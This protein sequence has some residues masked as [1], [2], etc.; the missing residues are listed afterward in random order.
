MVNTDE[1]RSYI[2]TI[3]PRTLCHVMDTQL[4]VFQSEP[5]DRE[6]PLLASSQ[7]A[8]CYQDKEEATLQ[9]NALFPER[10]EQDRIAFFR[11]MSKE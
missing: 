2:A 1:L 5:P 4:F 3:P 10:T 9:W 8:G 6:A 11:T 7:G